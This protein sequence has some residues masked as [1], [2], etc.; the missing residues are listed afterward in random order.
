MRTMCYIC[1]LWDM[2]KAK[3]KGHMAEKTTWRPQLGTNKAMREFYC[4]N[5]ECR[6]Y[7]VLTDAE[8]AK[9]YDAE[10]RATN[11][12]LSVKNDCR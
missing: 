9:E 7:K 1:R 12:D 5:C 6:T 2:H 3:Y 8:L 11:P 10:R 4:K